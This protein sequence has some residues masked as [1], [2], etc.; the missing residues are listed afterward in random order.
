M[1]VCLEDS[2]RV[3]RLSWEGLDITASRLLEQYYAFSTPGLPNVERQFPNTYSN[4]GRLRHAGKARTNSQQTGFREEK[5]N[6]ASE[7]SGRTR[8]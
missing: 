7:A 4:Q 6:I 3:M 2:Q 8:N 1:L 5:K